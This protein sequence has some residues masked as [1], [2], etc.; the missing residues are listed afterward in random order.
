MYVKGP[1]TRCCHS[2]LGVHDHLRLI[3]VDSGSLMHDVIL[4]RGCIVVVLF[5]QQGEYITN[6]S[7]D[8]HV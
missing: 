1:G 4:G 8:G 3:N 6:V 7:E 2:S 5:V